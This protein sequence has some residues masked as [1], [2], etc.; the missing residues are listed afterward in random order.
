[1]KT[2][3]PRPLRAFDALILNAY[4][5]SVNLQTLTL[6]PMLLPI[7]VERYMGEAVKGSAL[8]TLRLVTLM[9]SLLVHAVAAQLSDRCTSKLGRRRPFM[10]ASLLLETLTLVGMGLVITHLGGSAHVLVFLFILLAMV[11]SNI[12][13]G[14]A[15]GLIPDLV[16]EGQHGRYS[17]VKALFELP[18]P[19]IFVSFTIAKWIAAE[20]L[21]PVLWALIAVKVV[22]GVISLFI[23]EQAI[24]R[25]AK[26]FDKD[27]LWRLIGMT[28][29]FT[30]VIVLLGQGARF[31]LPTLK[32]I[33]TN[34]QLY[35]VLSALFGVLAMLVAVVIGVTISTRLTLSE[36][37]Q[38]RN[39]F[40]WWVINRLAFMVGAANLAG[41]VLYFLQERFPELAGSAAAQPTAILMLVI[42]GSLL[43][44]AVLSGWLTDKLGPKPVLFASGV[45]AFVAS[46]MVI[47]SARLLSVYIGAGFIGVAVGLFYSA[48][49]ALGTRLVP[50]D[51]AGRWLGISNIAG[52]GA[53]AVGAYIGGPI[54]DHAGFTVLMAV[55]GVVFLV[56]TLALFG[57]KKSQE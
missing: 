33:M 18:L 56:S 40:T 48:N 21:W 19:V 44:A 27:N 10:F 17:A 49:W 35:K 38:G 41:F 43:V 37:T 24:L 53:G 47:L 15:Q 42:G 8:G 20:Q 23:P 26:A 9:L 25:P 36:K 34:D 46:F 5:F 1:M 28:L 52:A 6:V 14:P 16:P 45:L 29:A 55:Y 4:Y 51:E 57:I 32:V 12:G 31:A 30:A 13:L 54:G 11:F 22:A 50:K 3:E 7:L 39:A 2:K